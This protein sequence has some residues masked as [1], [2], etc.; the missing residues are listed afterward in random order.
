LDTQ[1]LGV[2]AMEPVTCR[3][4]A[5]QLTVAQ[6]LFTRIV[7]ITPT[8]RS[9]LMEAIERLNRDPFRELGL[10]GGLHLALDRAYCV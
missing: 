2:F 9:L 10:S 8:G 6:G 1:N 5:V 7:E 3:S 4:T